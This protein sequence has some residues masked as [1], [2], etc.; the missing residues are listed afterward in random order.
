MRCAIKAMPTAAELSAKAG[1]EWQ[2]AMK[3]VTLCLWQAAMLNS[4]E[5]LGSTCCELLAYLRSE[6]FSECS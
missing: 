2:P 5:I 4:V 3:R 1:F 6:R